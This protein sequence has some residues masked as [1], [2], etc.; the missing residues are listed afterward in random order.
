MQAELAS[1]LSAEEQSFITAS[2]RNSAD[3][4]TTAIYWI[5]GQLISNSW[6]WTDG[7]P[8]SFT[9]KVRNIFIIKLHN[10]LFV[11]YTSKMSR[12]EKYTSKFFCTP[13]LAN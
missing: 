9:G 7:T 4:S 5:G 10:F 13:L 1:V 3:Y 8:L 2:L 6:M 12:I 11:G